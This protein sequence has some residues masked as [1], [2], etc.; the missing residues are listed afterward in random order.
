[1]LYVCLAQAALLAVLVVTFASLL[2]S[3]WRAQER[4]EQLHV[5]QLLHAAGH[6]WQTAPADEKPI[7]AVSDEEIEANVRAWTATPEQD[8]IF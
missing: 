8:P 4:R 3:S 5:N 2:R 6:A 1:M 7:I